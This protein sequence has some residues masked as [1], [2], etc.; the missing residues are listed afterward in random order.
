MDIGEQERLL[1]GL[2]SIDAK[3]EN[4]FMESLERRQ[5]I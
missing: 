4:N 1:D 5:N 3:N 2:Y